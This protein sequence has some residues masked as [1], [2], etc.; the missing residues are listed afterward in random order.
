[1]DRHHDTYKLGKCVVLTRP[2]S[3]ETRER[4]DF[5]ERVPH[6]KLHANALMHTQGAEGLSLEWVDSG[7]QWTLDECVEFIHNW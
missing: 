7:Q 1:M 6:G 5:L 3:S 4:V 2:C